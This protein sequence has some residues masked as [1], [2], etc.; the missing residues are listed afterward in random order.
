MM[1]YCRYYQMQS[2]SNNLKI[3]SNKIILSIFPQK[4]LEIV[5]IRTFVPQRKY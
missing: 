2:I 3:Y 5:R 1:N 4:S